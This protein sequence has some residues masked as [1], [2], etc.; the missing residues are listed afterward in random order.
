MVNKHDTMSIKP[1]GLVSVKGGVWNKPNGAF[2]NAG[3][4]YIQDT[5]RSD[6]GNT[7]F[8]QSWKGTTYLNGG[9]QEITGNSVPKFYKLK[10]IGTPNSIKTLHLNAQVEDTL[11]LNDHE[12]ATQQFTLYS[13]TTKLNAITRTTGFVSSLDTGALD[14]RTALNGNYLFPVGSSL[15]TSRYRPVIITPNTNGFNNFAVRMANI[16][17]TLETFDRNIKDSTICQVN[18]QY[19][20]RIY[21]PSGNDSADVR[22]FY[23]ATADGD[24]E[25]LAHW[26]HQPRW[27]NIAPVVQLPPQNGL[28]SYV[29]TNWADFSYSPFAFINLTPL[30]TLAIQPDSV[31]FKQA[32][33]LTVHPGGLGQYILI[34]NASDTL[35]AGADTTWTID[36]LAPGRHVLTVTIVKTNGCTFTTDSVVAIIHPLPIVDA[37]RD[38]FICYGE[39]VVLGGNPTVSGGSGSFILHWS[40]ANALSD[41]TIPNPIANPTQTTLYTVTAT[42]FYGC[43]KTD[44]ILVIVNPE[45]FADAGRDTTVC[46]KT[47]VILGGNPSGRGGSGTLAYSWQPTHGLS[48]PFSPN[49][50]AIPDSTTQYIITITD[51][52]GCQKTDSII[53]TIFQLPVI[54][55]GNDTLICYGRAVMLG[56]NPT[57]RGGSSNTFHYSWTPNTALSAPNDPNPIA[58]PTQTTTYYLTVT[59]GNYCIQTDSV[60]ISINPQISIDAGRDTVICWKEPIQLGGQPTASGGNNTF[61]YLWAPATGLNDPTSSNPIATPDSTTRYLLTITDGIGCPKVDTVVVT[62]KYLVA[63]TISIQGP[64]EFCFGDSVIL[65]SSF[66]DH[67]I[68]NTGDTTQSIVVSSPGVYTVTTSQYCGDTVS[69]PT[70]ITVWSNPE[71]NFG[72]DRD[73]VFAQVAVQFRDSSYADITRWFWDFGDGKGQSLEQNP[74]Y[75]YTEADTYS[76]RLIVQNEH[77]CADTIIKRVPV[78]ELPNLWVPSAFTPNGDGINDDFMVVGTGIIEYELMVFDRWGILL[79]TSTDLSNRWDGR[80]GGTDCSEGVYVYRIKAK[81]IREK[82]FNL[83]GTITLI[84]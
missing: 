4:F 5:V 24:F 45:M 59:D 29:K 25:G 61:T 14:R 64:T 62:V 12:F 48:D 82:V 50:I 39:Q 32:V 80:K 31:C 56:G 49:P 3:E 35:Y 83:V 7:F 81:N 10:L 66:A 37:G 23:D 67:Y 11:T 44:S 77:G 41:S 34:D 1:G 13:L 72:W 22:V 6:G 57:A 68:W 69:A 16:D 30:A 53:V 9:S 15:G 74:L 71:A 47:P 84:R 60:I 20:H 21:H 73:T 75:T 42:D 78:L 63:P 33:T 55:A 38:T 36:T 76:V 8:H 26:Q 19:Y 79:Y 17:A 52:T 54:D 65:T 51:T 18:P 43:T 28:T 40:P 27:E 70:L 46:R 58:N 2:Y